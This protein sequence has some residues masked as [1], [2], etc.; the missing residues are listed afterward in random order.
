MF[1][2]VASG[3]SHAAFNKKYLSDEVDNN[4]YGEC[5]TNINNMFKAINQDRHRMSLLF[6]AYIEK[7]YGVLFNKLFYKNTLNNI[8][9]DSG[10]LQMI[11]LGHTSTDEL[12]NSVY[13]IQSNLSTVGMCFDEIPVTVN[14]NEKTSTTNMSARIYDVNIFAQ[15]AKE[16]GIN[17]KNQIEYFKNNPNNMCKPM[18]ILQGNC[19]DTYQQWTDIVLN[20]IGHSNWKYIDGIALGGAALGQGVYEDLQRNFYCTHVELP[21]EIKIKHYHLLGVGSLFRMLPMMALIRDKKIDAHISYDSTT[22]T[23]GITRGNYFISDVPTNFP[24]YKDKY[25]YMVLDDIH[26]NMK[27]L[28]LNINITESMIYDRISI[29]SNWKKGNYTITDEYNILLAYLIS[30]I[31]NFMCSVDKLYEDDYYYEEYA[32]HKGLLIPLNAYSK[33]TDRKDFEEWMKCFKSILYSNP[34]SIK[35]N[36]D[37]SLYF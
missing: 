3:L 36:N 14:A 5:I 35:Q 33:C 19:F 27:K 37:L 16:T 18:I 10:G 2:Y 8:Y 12:K 25:F 29:P 21:S 32:H 15:K 11:T 9:S 6:N 20:E 4:L 30:S 34:V 26:K 24:Q 1:E 7:H 17:L 23:G 31:Y 22:H 13:D 28:N